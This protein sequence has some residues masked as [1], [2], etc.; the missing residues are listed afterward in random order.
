MPGFTYK[1]SNYG[2]P[3]F[4][5]RGIGFF[6][7]ALAIAPAVSVYVDQVP[8]GYSVMTPGAVLDVERIVP[9]TGIPTQVCA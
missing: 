8:L 7:E 3:I 2:T 1:P 9:R 6:D 4:T 5:I